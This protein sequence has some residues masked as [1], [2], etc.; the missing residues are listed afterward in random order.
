MI[1]LLWTFALA[2]FA[3]TIGQN[4]FGYYLAGLCASLGGWLAT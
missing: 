4:R 1:I 3:A 2:T